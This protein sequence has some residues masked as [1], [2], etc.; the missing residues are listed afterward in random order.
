MLSTNFF[1]EGTLSRPQAEVRRQPAR[2]R[3][4]I[5]DGT[6]V[7]DQAR[8]T[9]YWCADVLRAS[10]GPTRSATTRTSSSRAPTSLSTGGTGSHNLVFGYDTF[11]DIRLAEN[12][13]SGSDYRILGTT[14]IMRDGV[15][16]PSW[17]PID[18]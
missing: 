2:R 10:A 13:Q 1:L 7:T 4:D 18:P 9:R 8:G 15:V 12:H 14:S 3:T 16:Y 5:I 11:N 6:L 17:T